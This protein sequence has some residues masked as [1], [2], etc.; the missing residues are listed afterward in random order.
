MAKHYLLAAA[1]ALLLIYVGVYLWHNSLVSTVGVSGPI[2]PNA[3]NEIANASV[4]GFEITS[5]ML[6]SDNS[7]Q[8]SLEQISFCNNNEPSQFVCVNQRYAANVSTQRVLMYAGRGEACPEFMLAG[9][10]SCTSSAGYCTV[11]DNRS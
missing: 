7:S 6:A 1:I 8:C 10:L 11:V 4:S 2:P 9:R 5:Q 3:Q